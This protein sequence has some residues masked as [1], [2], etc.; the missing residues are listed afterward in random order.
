MKQQILVVGAGFGGLWSALSAARLLDRHERHDVQVSLLAPQAELR[1]RP[2]FYEPDVGRMFA[3]LDALFDT[4]GIRFVQG[5]AERIDEQAQSVGYRDA[6][7]RQGELGYDRLVLATGSQLARPPVPG[8]DSH[9]FDVDQIES[10]ARLEAHLKAL[11][12]RPASPARNTVVVVGG[13]FTGIETATEM[14]ARLREALGAE[15]DIHVIVVDRGAQVA[16]ALGEGIRPSI[17]EASAKLGIEWVPD[18]S[19]AA[20]DADG[21]SLAD[22]RRID[23]HTVIWTG[24]LRAS[25]LTGQLSGER[26]ALGRLHVDGNLKVRGQAKVFAAGD[27]AYAATDDLGNHAVMSCQHAISLGRHAGNN[28]AADLLGVPPTPYRQPKYVTCLDLG[29]WGAVYTEGW[30]RQVKLLGEQAKELK[31]QINTLWIYPPA[32]DRSIA[33]AAADPLIPVA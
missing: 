21:V 11:R 16:A 13:G 7:G 28:A 6:A 27:V 19:V 1:I 9:A 25:P 31:T 3:P 15:Q 8:L 29:A 18:A 32:A 23:S 24:G 22:G 14:P 17:I 33:L 12:N 4:V 20:V 26:D 2:R 5:S 10:A 30:D